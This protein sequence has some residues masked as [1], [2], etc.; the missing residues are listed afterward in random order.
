MKFD[1]DL[2]VNIHDESKYLIANM[3]IE[4]ARSIAKG[5]KGS[6]VLLPHQIRDNYDV[7]CKE[8][9]SDEKLVST[10]RQ[11]NLSSLNLIVKT[12]FDVK[13]Q[14]LKIHA[15]NN[16]G[17]AFYQGSIIAEPNND[18]YSASVFKYG[19]QY[20]CMIQR[21]YSTGTIEEVEDICTTIWD[22]V[23]YLLEKYNIYFVPSD[24]F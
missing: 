14:W 15:D 5:V 13:W 10:V 1:I 20:T 21:V 3:C 7:F 6:E 8:N 4:N 12:Y 17:K 2:A 16:L 24:W 11:E 9:Q 23:V 19:E 18:N 22:S